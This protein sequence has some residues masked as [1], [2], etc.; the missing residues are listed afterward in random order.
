MM[1]R[2]IKDE[3]EVLLARGVLVEVLPDAPAASAGV[4]SLL[5]GVKSLAVAPRNLLSKLGLKGAELKKSSPL[6]FG[7]RCSGERAAAMLAALSPEERAT[8]P[9][10]VDITCHMCGKIHT[11]LTGGKA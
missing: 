2:E 7:C 5:D 11:I 9:P 6:G 8:L 4:L 1:H 3:V 10:T